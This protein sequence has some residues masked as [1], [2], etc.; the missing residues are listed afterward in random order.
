MNSN[1]MIVVP[2]HRWAETAADHVGDVLRKT[3]LASPTARCAMALAGGKTP[4]PV[5]FELAGRF[6][7]R[8]DWSRI[9]LFLSDERMVGPEDP[10]SNFRL[11]QETLLAV[12]SGSAPT[13][14][15]VSTQWDPNYAAAAYELALRESVRA[16]AEEVPL[17]DLILLGVGEDG[18][19]ASLFPNSPLLSETN[20]LVAAT[21]HP[22]SGQARLTFTLPLLAAARRI[23][24]LIRGE[25]KAEILARVYDAPPSPE[26]PVT[27]VAA[28]ATECVWIVDEPAASGIE[29]R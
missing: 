23:V 3:L 8:L 11:A 16:G 27:M 9:D 7:S 1:R 25:G 2:G 20:K 13:V 4:S 26:L 10:E 29:K 19:T 12:L 17:F 6:G 22:R 24:F 18:H 14:H 21:V 28:A 5:Y 15:A